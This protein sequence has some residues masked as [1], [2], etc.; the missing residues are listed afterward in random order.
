VTTEEDFQNALDA[1][2]KDWQT[3]LVF[4]DW[5]QERGDERA[6]GYPALG[7]M[8]LRAGAHP[9]QGGLGSLVGLG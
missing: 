2:P 9:F 4:A 7:L 5:L 6:E 8:Q 1:N 3:R